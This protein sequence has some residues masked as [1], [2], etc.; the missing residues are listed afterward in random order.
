MVELLTRLQIPIQKQL[1]VLLYCDDFYLCMFS[2]FGIKVE[3]LKVVMIHLHL[4]FCYF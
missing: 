3:T 1:A 4:I 2:I